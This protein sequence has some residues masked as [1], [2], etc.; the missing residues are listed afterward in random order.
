MRLK[1][2]WIGFLSIFVASL[3]IALPLHSET[4]ELDKDAQGGGNKGTS[5]TPLDSGS[6]PA[7]FEIRARSHIDHN[8]PTNPNAPGQEGTVYI[9]T[10]NKGTGVKNISGGGSAGISG[11]GGDRDE[12][13]IFTFDVPVLL[14]PLELGL[15]DIDFG[16]GLGNKDDPYIYLQLSTDAPNTYSVVIDESIIQDAFTST[17]SK[18]GI[19]NFEDFIGHPSLSG[20]TTST[21]ITSFKIRETNSKIFVTSLT[22][23]IPAP[24]P[25]TL[26]I[27]GSCLTYAAMK[28]KKTAK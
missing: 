1:K 5:F 28:R 12:E 21:L 8:Q 27:L 18:K 9:D 2:A 23:G 11:K 6:N 14:Y 15:N 4:I 25:G 24:E 3:L 19:V 26:L 10:H 16:S 7:N 22:E 20:L 17:G 13:L